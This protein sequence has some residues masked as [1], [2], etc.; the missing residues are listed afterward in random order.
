MRNLRE[1][2]KLGIAV[3]VAGAVIATVA[4]GFS[5][6]ISS[7]DQCRATVKKYVTAEYSEMTVSMCTDFEGNMSTCMETDYWSEPA[8]DVFVALTV[9]GELQGR[10][11]FETDLRYGAHYPIMP[12][13]DTRMRS[14]PDFDNFEYHTN[15]SLKVLV[16]D[17]LTNE[18]SVFSEP[19][20]D[21]SKCINKLG[22]VITVDNWY[23]ITYSSDF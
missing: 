16:T 5:N 17:K 7:V 3:I 15:A 4:S 13:H 21:N 23:G 8:S 11:Y 22:G 19:M 20:S 1:K 9:N 12:A 10:Q 14:H 2:E 18:S 6:A